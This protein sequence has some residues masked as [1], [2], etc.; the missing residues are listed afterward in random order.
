MQS[1]SPQQLAANTQLHYPL[2]TQ[3]AKTYRIAPKHANDIVDTVVKVGRDHH[4]DPF[5][6]LGIIAKESS[7]NL[8]ARSGY[9]ATG[10]MQ[11]HAPSHRALLKTLGLNVNNLKSA[12]KSLQSEVHT[13]VTAGVRI[14]KQY[15][16]QYASPVQA[17]QAYNGTKTDSTTKY[18]RSVLA[19][20]DA[21]SS[22]AAELACA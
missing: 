4:V 9:G 17:L 5:L 20:R 8:A 15:E 22:Q 16:N 11:V 21:F 10:L 18:A 14:Y 2:A 1:T 13:N 19:L 12:E 3:L 6:I 7:F